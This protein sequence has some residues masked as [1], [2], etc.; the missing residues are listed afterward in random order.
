MR[1]KLIQTTK[2]YEEISQTMEST[3]EIYSKLKA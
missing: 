2:E 1:G 3:K